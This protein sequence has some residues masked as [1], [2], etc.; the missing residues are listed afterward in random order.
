MDGER[1][2]CPIVPDNAIRYH[3]GPD[4]D[5]YLLM[6]GSHDSICIFPESK[7]NHLR[8]YDADEGR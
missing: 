4:E 2:E 3:Y 6:A 5:D 8:Y 1:K 7:Y